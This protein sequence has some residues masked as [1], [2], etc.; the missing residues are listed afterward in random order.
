MLGDRYGTSCAPAL[1]DLVEVA[2]RE[3][4]YTVVRNKPYAGGFITEHYGEPALGLHALQIEI[5]RA[6]YMDERSLARRPD[7]ERRRRRSARRLRG[8]RCRGR[9]RAEP[10]TASP[11]SSKTLAPGQKKGR[12]EGGPSLGRKRPRR[13]AIPRRQS[14][15]RTAQFTPRRTNC[16]PC[17]ASSHAICAYRAEERRGV[18][19]GQLGGVAAR[20]PAPPEPFTGGIRTSPWYKARAAA[21][22]TPRSHGPDRLFARSSTSSRPCPARRS[23]PSSAPRSRP[24]TSRTAAS[25]IR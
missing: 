15:Y 8:R 11:P 10:A 2:L 22:R 9:G 5:N 23:C 19:G 6:L 21:A 17:Q 13:A 14:R 16:K 7:F 12:T 1:T 20:P 25:S 4:G 24:R 3:R 18:A